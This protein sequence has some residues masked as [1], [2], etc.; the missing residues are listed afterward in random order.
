MYFKKQETYNKNF[1]LTRKDNLYVAIKFSNLGQRTFASKKQ[2]KGRASLYHFLTEAAS[3][4]KWAESQEDWFKLPF[5]VFVMFY[6][7]NNS[8][9]FFSSFLF[10]RT[11]FNRVFML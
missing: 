6:R 2:S 11:C 8:F 10:V 5:L 9:S 3:L 7:N 4:Q 1:I